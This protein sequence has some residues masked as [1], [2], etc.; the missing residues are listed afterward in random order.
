MILL[1]M[2]FDKGDNKVV[3]PYYLYRYT[4]PEN[5]AVFH[6][7]TPYNPFNITKEYQVQADSLYNFMYRGFK[8]WFETV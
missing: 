8:E 2:I 1:G 7:I 4:T 3:I 5:K 6:F